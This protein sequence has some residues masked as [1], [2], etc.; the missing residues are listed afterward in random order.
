MVN[1]EDYDLTYYS[2]QGCGVHVHE[3]EVHD[4]PVRVDEL[5]HYCEDCCPECNELI[6]SDAAANELADAET[7]NYLKGISK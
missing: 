6:L 4:V 3:D 2:C 7:E 1:M 5:E